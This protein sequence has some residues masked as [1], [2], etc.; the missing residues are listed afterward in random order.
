M[1]KKR[2]NLEKSI[3]KNIRLCYTD[4]KDR[5][6]IVMYSDGANNEFGSEHKIANGIVSK[7]AK[8]V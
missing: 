3:D 5:G 8:N 6:A 7:K 2:Q 1:I 4:K